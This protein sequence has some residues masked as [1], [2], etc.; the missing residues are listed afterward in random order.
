MREGGQGIEISEQNCK[1]S[2]PTQVICG[3]WHP[4]ILISILPYKHQERSGLYDKHALHPPHEP[5]IALYVSVTGQLTYENNSLLYSRYSII[6]G[7]KI[8]PEPIVCPLLEAGLYGM[9]GKAS[10]KKNG[11]PHSHTCLSSHPPQGKTT[12]PSLRIVNTL[13]KTTVSIS[14][15]VWTCT[16]STH[17]FFSLGC[18]VSIA[19]TS[20]STAA[21]VSRSSSLHTRLDTP[22]L[23]FKLN[24]LQC[25]AD[26]GPLVSAL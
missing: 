16:R 15:S 7:R 13:L 18:I 24:L 23:D 1:K 4:L 3:V 9:R 10:E 21:Y 11:N 8:N 5:Q 25:I 26:I 22:E 2:K 14:L 6:T 19:I 17:C 20:Q 12:S